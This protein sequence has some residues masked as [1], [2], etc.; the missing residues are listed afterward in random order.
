VTVNKDIEEYKHPLP[1]IEELFNAL[2]GG[3]YF[4]KLDFLNAYNQIPL[5]EETQ[6]LLAWS[7]NKGIFIPTRLPFCTK[8]A[9]SI[10]QHIVEKVLQGLNG[11]INFQDDVVIT[12]ETDEEH[13]SNLEK[14]FT[15][16]SQAG[17]RLK[18]SKCK[19]FQCQIKYLG[20]I[21]DANGIQKDPDR[22]KAIVE[23]P[24][25]K[26]I[27]E[28]RAF[29]GMVNFYGKFINQLANMLEPL[30]KLLR[31]V[32]EFYWS[33]KC[34]IAFNKCKE[35]ITSNNVLTHYNLSLPIKVYCDA[36]QTVIA[37][38]MFQLNEEGQ[39]RPV[40][41]I[42]RTLNETEWRYSVIHR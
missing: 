33:E 40:S 41:F 14:V 30:Y 1:R 26:N 34:D 7:T 15:R 17:L 19:F 38:V 13:L 39:E 23:V 27:T 28:V 11:L 6:Y 10:F 20:H 2:K 37:A 12:G 25:P 9:S 35:V 4:T 22:I 16:F 8:S 5:T 36:S 32:V 18:L 31:K 21:V 42:P 24:K 3:K 29:I